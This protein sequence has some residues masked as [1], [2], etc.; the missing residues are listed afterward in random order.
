MRIIAFDIG[1]KKIGVA[2]SDM[3]GITASPLCIIKRGT[4][5][6]QAAIE[7]IKLTEKNQAVKIIIGLPLSL[8]GNESQSAQKVRAFGSILQEYS[9]LSIEYYDESGST[10]QAL[11]I[12]RKTKR[13]KE[14]QNMNDDAIAAAV[15][16]RNY[17][18]NHQQYFNL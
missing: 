7:L 13:L 16:L 2:V 17:L 6:N 9:T 5:D 15:I 10:K 3:L 12:M 1:D 8:D 14:R 4:D 11:D 18:E